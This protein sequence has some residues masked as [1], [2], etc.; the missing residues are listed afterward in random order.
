MAAVAAA[1]NLTQLECWSQL[2][3]VTWQDA[4]CAAASSSRRRLGDGGPS[5]AHPEMAAAEGAS[6]EVHEGLACASSVMCC[7]RCWHSA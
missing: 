7:R 3:K 6:G 4:L 1:I 5:E 2:G